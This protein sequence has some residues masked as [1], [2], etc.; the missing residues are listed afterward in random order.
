MRTFVGHTLDRKFRLNFK[1]NSWTTFV[2]L[3]RYV[4]HWEISPYW[5]LA[6]NKTHCSNNYFWHIYKPQVKTTTVT[7]SADISIYFSPIAGAGSCS[8]AHETSLFNPTTLLVLVGWLTGLTIINLCY[9]CIMCCRSVYNSKF[10]C[11]TSVSC[12]LD[13]SAWLIEKVS[14]FYLSIVQEKSPYSMIY[15]FVDMV[16][17]G[18]ISLVN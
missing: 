14:N 12:G 17:R 15:G 4:D 7:T 1:R 18:S 16:I 3:A 8:C 2:K 10:S 6:S 13:W 11:T 9:I 5:A